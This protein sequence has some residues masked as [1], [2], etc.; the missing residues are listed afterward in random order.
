MQRGLG[1]TLEREEIDQHS[2]EDIGESADSLG[3]KQVVQDAEMTKRQRRNAK[4]QQEGA[5]P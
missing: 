5:P 1:P 2:R 3:E 4:K